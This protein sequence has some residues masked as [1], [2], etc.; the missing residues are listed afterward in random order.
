MAIIFSDYIQVTHK[1][2]EI[3]SLKIHKSNDNKFMFD[4]RI[5]GKRQ[6]KVITVNGSTRGKSIELAE[7]A[8]QQYISEQSKTQSKS[9]T[10]SPQM[11]MNDYFDHLCDIKRNSWS[12][13]HRYKLKNFFDKYVKDLIGDKAVSAVKSSD[14]TTIASNVSHLSKRSQKRLTEVLHPLCG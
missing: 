5:D 13:D 4:L 3:P 1:G 7:F 9:A 8:L 10:A 11:S 12:D 2:R 14:I 6:R